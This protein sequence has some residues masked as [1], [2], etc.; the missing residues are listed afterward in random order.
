MER[1]RGYPAFL[2]GLKN[3]QD[4]IVINHAG[5]AARITIDNLPLRQNRLM[6]MSLKGSIIGA[7]AAAPEDEILIATQSGYAKR[8]SVDS[9]PYITEMNS[10]G[11]KI[12]QRSHVVSAML[13]QPDLP[14]WALSNKG[15]LPV[16]AQAIPLNKDN[17]SEHTLFKMKK[18]E[19]LITLFT[20]P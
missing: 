3:E 2:T 20:L 9:I 5:R 16:D 7:L 15:I 1:K 4:Y 19:K 14:L 18:G 6:S 12:V 13:Y 11:A 8:I 17:R 10:S